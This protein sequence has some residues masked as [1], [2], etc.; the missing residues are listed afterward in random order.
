MNQLKDK[1][2]TL[3]LNKLHDTMIKTALKQKDP[4]SL[5]VSTIYNNCLLIL[6]NFFIKDKIPTNDEIELIEYMI[7][8]W[9]DWEDDTK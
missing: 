6:L 3:K 7:E 2:L 1:L 9:E 4:H 8:Q 5:L